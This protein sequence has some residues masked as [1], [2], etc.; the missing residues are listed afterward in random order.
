MDSKKKPDSIYEVIKGLVREPVRAVMEQLYGEPVT[1]EPAALEVLE[2]VQVLEYAAERRAE[3]RRVM[4]TLLRRERKPNG[5]LVTQVF[6]DENDALMCKGKGL[7]GRSLQVKTFDA[8]LADI[9]GE[10]ESAVVEL[11]E[12]HSVVVDSKKKPDGIYEVIKG[13]VRKPVRAVMEQLYG[14]PV[15]R[16]PAALEV[17]EYVQV[18]EYA[19]E[20]RA[21]DRRVM[22]T[23]L[24]RERKPEAG[25]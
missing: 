12:Q 15:T 5:W 17:L 16:E 18:L 8:E 22:A 25:W 23:L 24:R 14:E 2:Y 10:E 7:L 1:R 9:F 3:D 6:M 13:L 4:A 11:P 20:R 19:A 21:E